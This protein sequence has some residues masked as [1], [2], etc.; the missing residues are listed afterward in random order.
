MG[1]IVL[2][3]RTKICG[4]VIGMIK[5]KWIKIRFNIRYSK[6]GHKD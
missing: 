2:I 4:A 3:S 5:E 6:N 1:W